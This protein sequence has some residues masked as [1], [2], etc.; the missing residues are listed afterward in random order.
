[1]IIKYRSSYKIN[2]YDA[3]KIKEGTGTEKTEMCSILVPKP[4]SECKHYIHQ[5]YN[6][7]KTKQIKQKAKM[8][9]N[10]KKNSLHDPLSGINL[11]KSWRTLHIR[12]MGKELMRCSGV[13]ESRGWDTR[14]TSHGGRS[15]TAD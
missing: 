9:W 13:P 5:T 8:E 12:A 6:K 14:V 2:K 15:L 3:G 10:F 4:Y 11:R 1:M 7:S